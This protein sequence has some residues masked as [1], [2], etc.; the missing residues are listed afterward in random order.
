MMEVVTP[1]TP[2]MLTD[3]YKARRNRVWAPNL[4]YLDYVFTSYD[5]HG[6]GSELKL[7]PVH[8]EKERERAKKLQG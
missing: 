8:K 3:M 7:F 5:P 4:A 1:S 6:S 2:T